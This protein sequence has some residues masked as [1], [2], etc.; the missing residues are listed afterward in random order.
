[1]KQLTYITAFIFLAFNV[2]AIEDTNLKNNDHL[3]PD[4]GDG[5]SAEFIGTNPS[6][7]GI[8]LS[9]IQLNNKT[10]F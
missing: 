6:N 5:S 4:E 10:T 9:I 2:F 8:F 7:S 1:L 3:L